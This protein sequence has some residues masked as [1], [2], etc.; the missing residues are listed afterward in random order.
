M[1]LYELEIMTDLEEEDGTIPISVE[2]Q[3]YIDEK[4]VDLS[5]NDELAERH[6]LTVINMDQT[7]D[8]EEEERVIMDLEEEDDI[9][10]LGEMY[11]RVIIAEVEEHRIMQEP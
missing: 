4:V 8:S 9:L 11:G 10:V 2:I 3:D 7:D 6:S 1:L 5:N